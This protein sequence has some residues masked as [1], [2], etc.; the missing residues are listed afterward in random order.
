MPTESGF[1]LT[2][3]VGGP[4][5][6]LS[7]LTD[8]RD[9]VPFRFTT[10]YATV[11]SE[12]P[13]DGNLV[14]VVDIVAFTNRKPGAGVSVSMPTMTVVVQAIKGDPTQADAAWFDIATF[15]TIRPFVPLSS[16]GVNTPA[17]P[18]FSNRYRRAFQAEYSNYRF[19]GQ[20]VGPY[21]DFSR[22]YMAIHA[23][24]RRSREQD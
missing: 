20:F 4:V 12:V 2:H 16:T 10:G 21:P 6:Y 23:G 15:N 5:H 22:V 8:M 9:G 3:P 17:N 7:N 13:A 18:I 1:V 11:K 19:S 24:T 14:G